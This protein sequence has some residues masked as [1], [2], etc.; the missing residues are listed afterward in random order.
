MRRNQIWKI[1]I[2][3]LKDWTTFLIQD[4]LYFLQILIVNETTGWDS[5]AASLLCCVFHQSSPARYWNWNAGVDNILKQYRWNTERARHTDSLSWLHFHTWAQLITNQ[6]W[7]NAI[8]N[9]YRPSLHRGPQL[10]YCLGTLSAVICGWTTQTN[11][12]CLEKLSRPKCAGTLG[13]TPAASR[14]C[15][16]SATMSED[17]AGFVVAVYTLGSQ[18]RSM[19]SIS[20]TPCP[21]LLYWEK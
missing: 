21:S 7:G 16:L 13:W 12:F 10:L 11:V 2:L 19:Y 5:L 20:V 15:F 1:W 8:D 9:H 4:L 14:P 6:Q 18:T 3:L 17:S